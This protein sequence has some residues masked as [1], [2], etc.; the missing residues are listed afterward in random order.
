MQQN[1]GK[2]ARTCKDLKGHIFDDDGFVVVKFV[3]DVIP[4]VGPTPDD[5]DAGRAKC[6]RNSLQ[7]IELPGGDTDFDAEPT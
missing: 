3:L 7:D 1:S 4:G 5:D 6:G 2:G